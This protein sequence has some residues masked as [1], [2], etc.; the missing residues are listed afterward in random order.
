MQHLLSTQRENQKYP[1][2]LVP[3][4]I[5]ALE[6]MIQLESPGKWQIGEIAI[7]KTKSAFCLKIAE[8][9]KKCWRILSIAAE[10]AIDFLMDG[11]AFCLRILYEKYFLLVNTQEHRALSFRFNDNAYIYSREYELV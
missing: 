5:Q 11:F 7:E 1:E 4:C 3:T 8:S 10:D 2:I 6:V 9:M